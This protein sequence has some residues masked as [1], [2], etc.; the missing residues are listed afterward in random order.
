MTFE[1]TNP[2]NNR[3]TLF[4]II[5]E[6][7]WQMRCEM[8]DAFWTVEEININKDVNDWKNLPKSH[9][10]FI[11]YTLAFFAS[12]DNVINENLVE[13][14]Y[15]D[16][17]I[18]E[19]KSF[20]AQQICNEDIHAETY[21]KLIDVYY[22]DEPKK[23]EQMFNA[24][25]QIPVVKAKIE[26]MKKW[27]SSDAPINQRLV[28]NAC[29]EGIFF[30]SPFKSIDWVCQNGKLPGLKL[31]NDFISRDEFHH[32]KFSALL[33]SKYTKQLP[34]E[35]VHEMV[36]ECV[37]IEESFVR[38]SLPVKLIDMSA[39]TMCQYVRYVADNVLTYLGH[40]TIF[41]VSNPFP[42]M[43]KLQLYKKSNF[44]EHRESNYKKANIYSKEIK[45]E[46]L[47]DF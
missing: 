39:D 16:V 34:E 42:S 33:Y 22:K 4:P 25:T 1:L 13:R 21:A 26:W 44:F 31:S 18:P 45:Y 17:T 32:M 46:Q 5:Y 9:R 6:D 24:A 43:L 38:Q 35:T 40:S 37:E 41:N 3:L 29:I 47:N 15:N 30:S 28:A 20:Y 2:K 27:I 8:R 23:K 14:F 7:I 11:G 10:E 12:A 19:A 36:R